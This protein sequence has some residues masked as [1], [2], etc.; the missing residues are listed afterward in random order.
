VHFFTSP[1]DAQGRCLQ[2]SHFSTAF[3]REDPVPCKALR[4]SVA[5]PP[6]KMSALFARDRKARS[7]P[8]LAIRS[9]LFRIRLSRCL[10]V[11][12]T[13]GCAGVFFAV[14]HTFWLEGKPVD[15]S[16][17]LLP[18]LYPLDV[19]PVSHAG[20]SCIK[21]RPSRVSWSRL[22]LGLR[23]KRLIPLIFRDHRF[24]VHLTFR[25]LLR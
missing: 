8:A 19:F 7:P 22:S 12:P 17:A 9:G 2:F 5:P 18:P 23:P 4:L 24:N 10:E 13:P 3:P 15:R 16:R 14:S 6:W 21:Y 11:T 1:S 25:G 20:I